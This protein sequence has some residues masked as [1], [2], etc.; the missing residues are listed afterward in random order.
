[1]VPIKLQL[2]NFLSYREPQPL[3]FTTFNLAVLSGNNGVGKS[4]ILEAISWALWGQTRAGSDDDLIC[5][6]T[7]GAWVE[8]IFEHEGNL[9][10]VVR[11]REKK[12]KSGQSFLE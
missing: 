2:H 12:N 7:T 6:G 5:Q 10:R 4:S 8:L 9:Y 11:K 3:D 1:M